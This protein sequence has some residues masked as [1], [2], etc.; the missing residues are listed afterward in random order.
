MQLSIGMR[1]TAVR[2]KISKVLRHQ[3]L[4]STSSPLHSTTPSSNSASSNS[5]S[6]ASQSSQ[7]QQNNAKQQQD[8]KKTMAELDEELRQKLEGMS[9]EGGAAGIELEDGKPVA[10][11]RGVRDNMFRLI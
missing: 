9:G 5:I 10:M 3:R 6:P 11:K 1:S 2:T 8:H 7:D 4:L